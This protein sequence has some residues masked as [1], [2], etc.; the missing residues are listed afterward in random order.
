MQ[1]CRCMVV[2][3]ISRSSIFLYMRNNGQV[4]DGYLLMWYKSLAEPCTHALQ[5]G[6]DVGLIC[7][8]HIKP[9]VDCIAHEMHNADALTSLPVWHFM[10]KHLPTQLHYNPGC[11]A[12]PSANVSQ[13]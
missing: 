12:E 2:I 3:K 10:D 13:T 5:V 4:V 7:L 1:I 11:I 6:I 8:L 9:V